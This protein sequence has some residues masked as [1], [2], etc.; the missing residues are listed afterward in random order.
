MSISRTEEENIGRILDNVKRSSSAGE[1]S[2]TGFTA[3]RSYTDPGT[4][5]AGTSCYPVEGV[6]CENVKLCPPTSFDDRL[7]EELIDKRANNSKYKKMMASLSILIHLVCACTPK[8]DISV[9]EFRGTLPSW[10]VRE[11]VLQLVQGH[12][13]CVISGETGC[14]KTTQVHTDRDQQAIMTLCELC[15]H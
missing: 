11:E 15:S 7:K 8:S 2:Q 10:A 5:S 9:Q 4:S 12:Q 14:G 13:V 6:D 1:T 3:S